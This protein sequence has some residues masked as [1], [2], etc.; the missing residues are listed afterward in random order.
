M[1]VGYARVSTQDQNPELQ[2]DALNKV[3]CVK[4]F[5]EKASGAQRDRYE[6][7]AA[8]EYMRSGD[9]LVVWK[10]DRL[11]RLPLMS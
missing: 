2:I 9:T 1:F 7:K 3:G 8:L 5:I 10:L 6:L 4:L 11:A